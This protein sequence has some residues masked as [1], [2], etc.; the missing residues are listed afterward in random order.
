MVLNSYSRYGNRV[1][2]HLLFFL[3]KICNYDLCVPDVP[4][5]LDGKGHVIVVQEPSDDENVDGKGRSSSEWKDVELKKVHMKVV[6]MGDLR[7]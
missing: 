3:E 5:F 7:N 4:K 2:S 6:K 1:C